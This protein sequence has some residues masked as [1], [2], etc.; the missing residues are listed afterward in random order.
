MIF[1]TTYQRRRV[2]AAITEVT[3]RP[4]N[5]FE[6]IRLKGIGSQKLLVRSSSPEIEERV[7]RKFNLKHCNIELRRKGIIIRF[8]SFSQTFAWTIPYRELSVVRNCGQ[9]TIYS[10]DGHFM[11]VTD[12]HGG[13]IDATFL[14]KM[15][16]FKA[17]QDL[18]S[19]EEKGSS[20]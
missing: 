20:R 1:D 7:C 11:S 17:E 18:R 9:L 13:K 10:K 19:Y 14:N 5:L 16:Q 15:M 8:G 6:R 4:F 2:R 3:G 12:A